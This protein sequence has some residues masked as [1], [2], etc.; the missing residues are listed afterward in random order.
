MAK[1]VVSKVFLDLGGSSQPTSPS[2]ILSHSLWHSATLRLE[3]SQEKP[4]DTRIK[5]F[6]ELFFIL[7]GRDLPGEG[8]CLKAV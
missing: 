5:R 6:K 3:S 2:K 7:D 1:L 8:T 4:E